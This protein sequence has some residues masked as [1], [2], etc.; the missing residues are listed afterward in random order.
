[1]AMILETIDTIAA[2]VETVFAAYSDHKRL[3]MLAAARGIDAAPRGAADAG[4][5]GRA[6]QF[7][8]PYRGRLWQALVTV[9]RCEPPRE[10]L[11][12]VSGK[13]VSGSLLLR[14][15]SQGAAV[16]QV[17]TRAEVAGVSVPARL[18]VASMAVAGPEVRRRFAQRMRGYASLVEAGLAAAATR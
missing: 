14:F 2:P 9:E 6:W 3:A 16:T 15:E 12:R 5:Q 18:L 7:R 17:Q 4:L 8:V 10:V 1:M 13:M 11:V